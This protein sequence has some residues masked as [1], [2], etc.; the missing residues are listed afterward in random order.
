MATN[1]RSE[2]SIIETVVRIFPV[3]ATIA[4]GIWTMFIYFHPAQSAAVSSAAQIPPAATQS[5]PTPADISTGY[6]AAATQPMVPP[7]ATVAATEAPTIAPS[8]PPLEGAAT[9]LAAVQGFYG[10]LHDGRGQEAALL[11]VPEKRLSGPFAPFQLSNFYGN[12]RHPIELLNVTP[13]G[14]SSYQVHYRYTATKSACDGRALIATSSTQGRYF[15]SGIRA[16][17]G[18]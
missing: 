5:A 8:A 2:R 15:V 13:I 14:E 9:A 3:I 11:V 10:Y 16:I 17:D 7:Q 1:T 18:C 12:L 6:A 4:G